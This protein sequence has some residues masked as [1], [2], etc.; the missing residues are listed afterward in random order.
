MQENS[1]QYLN[2]VEVARY[3]GVSRMTLYKLIRVGKLIPG[4]WNHTQRW[5]RIG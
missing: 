1:D 2:L 3:I 4:L 5:F